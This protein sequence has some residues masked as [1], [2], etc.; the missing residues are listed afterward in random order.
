MP[1]ELRVAN[2]DDPKTAIVL[3]PVGSEI[4]VGFFEEQNAYFFELWNS[5]DRAEAELLIDGSRLSRDFPRGLPIVRWRWDIGFHAGE[6]ELELEISGTIHRLTVVTDPDRRKLTRQHFDLM[7]AQILEDTFAL[8]ALSSFRIGIAAGDTQPPPI[9]RLEYLR[10]RLDEIERT[11]REI[12]RRPVRILRAHPEQVPIHRARALSAREL[13]RSLG[14]G[15]SVE[16]PGAPSELGGHLPFKVEKSRRTQGLDIAE[17]RQI[18]S[19]LRAWADW[20][21]SVADQLLS[22]D[23]DEERKVMQARWALKC[24]QMSSRLTK[25]LRSPLFDE[26]QP[27]AAPVRPTPIFRR[28]PAYARFLRLHAE[29]RRGLARIFG[30]FL[31][32][33][34][35]RTYD[36]YE[37]WAFLRLARAASAIYPKTPF[38]PEKL[39]VKI[40]DGVR[41]QPRAVCL[42]YADVTLCFQR[43]YR[44]FWIE[45]DRRG[46]FSR[47]MRP[48]I[49]IEDA[50]TGPPV[51]VVVLDAKY[52]VESELNS[53]ISS[54][55]SYR[56]SLM[57]GED[58]TAGPLSRITSAGFVL[59]P[60]LPTSTSD[61]WTKDPLPARLFR[62]EYQ[63]RF[64]FGAITF[65]PGISEAATVELLQTMIAA[66]K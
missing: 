55:H 38:E 25:L 47:D 46:S 31:D 35:A 15:R 32:V 36:L 50:S 13:V 44:E 7:V 57:H 59:T 65:R 43:T 21:L 18:K 45:S 1:A 34:L 4:P 58:P 10:S 56:D 33:P 53:A 27:S 22:V 66:C 19:A 51:H 8:L 17:H 29:L 40:V 49:A 62:P 63:E 16:A 24:R 20:L 64:D 6:I 5:S 23:D 42:S 54:I 48:D 30:D 2:T 12:E 52:R 41:L 60:Y 26:V 37:I 3:W 39:F 14:R 9:A 11:V 61:E 28:V